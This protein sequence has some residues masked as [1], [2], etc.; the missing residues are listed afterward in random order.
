MLRA[1]LE[2]S[3]PSYKRIQKGRK[4]YV[5]GLDAHSYHH[6][7]PRSEGGLE[8]ERNLIP[9][10]HNCHDSLE[11]ASWAEIKKAKRSY[12]N[13]RATTKRGIW[14][15]DEFGNTYCVTDSEEENI[16]PVSSV[17]KTV[18]VKPSVA[19]VL[20]L[21][22]P[23]VKVGPIPPTNRNYPKNPHNLAWCKTCRD[24]FCRVI[25]VRGRWRG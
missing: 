12:E 24:V 13:G 7:K 17:W 4:C 10:C 1:V 9:L 23:T 20:L 22:V 16:P 11:W 21:E 25:R 5:C 2:E 15:K 14:G 19:Q 6:I 3:S 18:R 8:I